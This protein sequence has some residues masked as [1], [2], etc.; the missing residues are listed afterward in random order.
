MEGDTFFASGSLSCK[1]LS[2]SVDRGDMSTLL[3]ERVI[4]GVTRV[5]GGA[6]EIFLFLCIPSDF[7]KDVIARGWNK[8]SSSSDLAE[9]FT[10]VAVVVVVVVVGSSFG[11]GAGPVGFFVTGGAAERGPV[12]FIGGEGVGETCLRKGTS[13]LRVRFTMVSDEAERL[14]GSLA[15][16]D[17]A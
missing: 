13:M 10:V 11:G 7:I 2:S 6:S 17:D 9:T 14:D 1:L 5:T 8:N 4:F 12:R 3:N 16:L 15:E